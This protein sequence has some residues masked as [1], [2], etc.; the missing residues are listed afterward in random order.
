MGPIF[1]TPCGWKSSDSSANLPKK[2]P[3]SNRSRNDPCKKKASEGVKGKLSLGLCHNHSMPS[4]GQYGQFILGPGSGFSRAP[5][6]GGLSDASGPEVFLLQDASIA[7]AC[8]KG[9]PLNSAMFAG[10]VSLAFLDFRLVGKMHN[11]ILAEI[12]A[13]E[14]IIPSLGTEG[15]DLA[16]HRVINLKVDRHRGTGRQLD[17]SHHRALD[18]GTLPQWK[19]ACACLCVYIYIYV[20]PHEC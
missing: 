1:S 3:H 2:S 17:D 15:L 13:S 19:T 9:I 10:K 14:E 8:P 11:T 4:Y 16:M 20:Y 7:V 12:M 18:Q 6:R 5:G